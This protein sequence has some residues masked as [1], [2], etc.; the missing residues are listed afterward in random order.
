MFFVNPKG[1]KRH[2]ILKATNSVITASFYILALSFKNRHNLICKQLM[3]TP[4]GTIGIPSTSQRHALLYRQF[5][6]KIND[7][8]FYYCTQGNVFISPAL[9]NRALAQQPD[10]DT[11]YK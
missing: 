2:A 5:G 4:T 10:D 8:I 9:C 3:R 7:R 11:L 6:K 1:I